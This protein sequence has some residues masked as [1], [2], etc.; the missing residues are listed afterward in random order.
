MRSFFHLFWLFG[1]FS[2]FLTSCQSSAESPFLS[3]LKAGPGAPLYTTYAAAMERSQFTLDEG[4]EFHFD[5][6]NSGVEFTTDT[7]GDLCI[8][9]REGQRWVYNQSDY[10]EPPVITASYPDLVHYNAFPLEGIRLDGR[11]L[12]YSSTAVIF[13]LVITN[14][15][16]TSRFLEVFPLMRNDYRTFGEVTELKNDQGLAFAH[17]EYPDSWTLG[18]EV[19]FVDSILN[20]LLISDAADEFFS[21]NSLDG[22][23]PRIPFSPYPDREPV[24]QLSGRAFGPSGQRLMALPPVNRFQVFL[25]IGDPDFLI[26]ENSPVWG[27]AQG[28]FN[29][30]GYYRAELGQLPGF[31]AARQF[32]FTWHNEEENRSFRQNHPLDHS[33]TSQRIDAHLKALKL[34]AIPAAT[35]IEVAPSLDKA[36]LSWEAPGP[37]L[38]I[39][40]YQRTYPEGIYRRLAKNLTDTVFTIEH[41]NPD[42]QLGFILTATDLA[43]G[44]TGMHTP[45]LVTVP[46]ASFSDYRTGKAPPGLNPDLAKILGMKKPIT[47]P[48]GG[49]QTLRLVRAVAPRQTSREDMALQT[50]PL[51]DLDLQPFLKR[52]EQLFAGVPPL[53]LPPE[54][55]ETEMLYW[56]AFNMM[57][58]V[59]YPPEGKSSYNYYVFSREPTWGWGHG[60]QVFH[61]SL[62]MATYAWLDPLSAMNSQRVYAERQYENGYINYRTGSYLDEIIEYQGQLTSSAPW[63]ART[64]WE[65]YQITRDLEFLREM[66]PSS[67]RFYQFYTSQ[68]DSDG[69][70]LCEWGGHAVLESVRDAAVA[71]WD[72]VG[73]PANFEALDLNCMLVS[74][75][76]ALAAMAR[77]LGLPDE[78]AAWQADHEKRSHL[79]NT[80]FW[81]EATGF[82]YQVDKVDHDFSYKQPGDLK[83]MEII[84]FLPLWAGVASPERA[85]RLLEHLTDPGKFWRPYGIPSLSA[86][87][88]FYNDKGYWNGPVWVEW[89]YLVFEGLLQYGFEASAHELAKRVAEGMINQLKKNHNLWEFYSPDTSWA[90]YHRTY[91]WA[92]IIN[93]ML[94]DTY[95]K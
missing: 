47:L 78:A 64:N 33:A 75:A 44:Q 63:Y 26:T 89:N 19:P 24:C 29:L 71:V 76:K 53:N 56:S 81:D 10:Y 60:G 70:G 13:E 8:G 3:S 1:T 2:F 58:Q 72:E 32:T 67:K 87:D 20:I 6:P 54:K 82:Y 69:D 50:L 74:E 36:T 55:E 91:I 39:N 38:A 27:N 62:T 40:I 28:A 92:G 83:R 25:G 49:S 4:Y 51:L 85:A 12:V 7:G 46:I 30:D 14:E 11:F 48:P 65:I 42:Q 57:R 93:S 90:G 5:R 9:F 17:E 35:K 21:F 18:H 68:R 66:Y 73:W 37:G 95:S 15:S 59:F 22:E 80:T 52:N 94:L 88:P 79:I 84:G 31:S 45:E 23:S 16:N 77:E 61:E 41:L 34:P 43:T 86:D